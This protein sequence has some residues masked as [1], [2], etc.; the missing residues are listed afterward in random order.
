MWKYEVSTS[1]KDG[2]ICEARSAG[3]PVVEVAAPPE[4]GGPEGTWT[5]ED[6]LAASIASCL[7]TSTL[8]FLDR[9]KIARSRCEVSA[10]ATMEKT[11]SGLA[12]SGI[13]ATVSVAL[14]DPAQSDAARRAAELAEKNCPVSKSLVCPVKLAVRIEA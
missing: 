4:F 12:F 1:W 2:R 8:F 10:V 14:D 3:K 7:L 9:A 13:E 11:A 6:L 5:P